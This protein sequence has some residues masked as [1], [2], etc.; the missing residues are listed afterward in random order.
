MAI[1][2]GFGIG[3]SFKQ[4]RF[5]A[6]IAFRQLI[7]QGFGPTAAVNHLRFTLGLGFRRTDMFA[8]YHQTR[9]EYEHE[10]AV[11]MAS[12]VDPI[13]EDTHMPASFRYPERYRYRVRVYGRDL[14]TGRFAATERWF[15]SAV[16][17][18]PD[19]IE[20]AVWEA[21]PS[22]FRE[23]KDRKYLHE[24]YDIKGVKVTAAQRNVDDLSA[25]EELPT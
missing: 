7:A 12:R 16:R 8:V 13:D 10:E 9:T 22:I 20:R 24:R 11:R 3:L 1:G 2:P 5:F 21:D 6:P 19:T 15:D 25:W 14:K 23:F 18:D 17:L 4:R